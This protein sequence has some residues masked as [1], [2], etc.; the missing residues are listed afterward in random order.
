MPYF[1]EKKKNKERKAMDVQDINN[2]NIN[3]SCTSKNRTFILQDLKR[4]ETYSNSISSQVYEIKKEL[5]GFPGT[6]CRARVIL[7]LDL[8]K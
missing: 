1:D 6:I 3:P 7:T 2:Y 5:I 4:I 8:P